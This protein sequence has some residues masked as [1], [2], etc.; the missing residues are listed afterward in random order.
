MIAHSAFLFTACRLF[1]GLLLCLLPGFIYSQPQ[2]PPAPQFSLA[3]LRFAPVNS[4]ARPTGLGGAFIGVAN[5]ATAAGINPAGVAFLARPEISLSQAWGRSLREFPLSATS[6]QREAI[7][8][9]NSALVNL[10]YPF[11][12]FTFALYRRLAFRSEFKFEREQFLTFSTTRPLTLREQ[13]GAA[14][15]FP[16]VRSEFSFEVWQDA[17]VI[18]KTIKRGVRIGAALLATQLRFGLHEQHY[19]APE[20][21]LQPEVSAGTAGPNRANGLYRIYH[22]QRNEF[23][24]A[25]NLGVLF[26]LHKNFSVG[27][28]YH[29]L[30]S[31]TIAHLRALPAYSLPDRTPND[32]S[33]N[34]LQFQAEETETPFELDLPDNWGFGLAWKPDGRNLLALDVVFHRSKTLLQGSA[35]NL[36]QD[37]LLTPEGD[38]IDPD[39]RVDL[40]A[41][42]FV[43]L[44]A[45][46]ERLLLFSQTKMPL[47]LGFYNEPLFGLR[48]A[49]EDSNLEREYPQAGARW[50][51][52]GGTGLIIKNFRFE[53]SLD[54]AATTMEAIGSAVVSF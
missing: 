12:G 20:L 38:Y 6:D 2:R 9:F 45:G 13:L 54:F 24:P 53:M 37:D 8:H 32:G 19:F 50:H 49:V 36:P 42:D 18:A 41:E 39:N 5:D 23:K 52:A 35:Q 11:K 3:Q 25:W 46:V 31:Y 28:A 29:H 44:R 4:A 7:L 15:N 51:V 10:V 21:W 48:V 40:V 14:G 47:R 33:D 43:S 1:L 26:E 27:A 22:A 34:A 17:F 16:G 30:P